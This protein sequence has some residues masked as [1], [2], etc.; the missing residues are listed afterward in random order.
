M[1]VSSCDAGAAASA[2]ELTGS[3]TVATPNVSAAVATTALNMSV[4][5]TFLL[6][7]VR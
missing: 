6:L 5:F 2:G 7:K 4:V 3:D 1:T